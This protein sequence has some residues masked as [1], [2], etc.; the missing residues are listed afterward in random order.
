MRAPFQVLVFPYQILNEQPRYL[1]GK[2]SDNG[3]W[4]AISGGG[5]DSE[6]MLEAA[7]RELKEETSLIGC[8]WQ[9]LD[10]M[11]MLPKVYYAGHE[12]W[13]NHQFVVPEYSFSARVST[14]PQL[15]NEHTKFRWCGF[16][17]ASELLKYDSNRIALW[18]LNQRLNSNL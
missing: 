15:S 4:Q 17:E 8:D 13:T 10:S 3:V 11:C 7:K 1:I 9:R 2:R 18:E 12:N 16:Q 14:E 5:E 6:S